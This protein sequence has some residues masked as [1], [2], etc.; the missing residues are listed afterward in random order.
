MNAAIATRVCILLTILFPTVARA[1]T[2]NT[3]SLAET[4]TDGTFLYEVKLIDEFLERFND[5]PNSYIRRE[6][7][8]LLGTDSIF[9]RR[10]MLHSLFN[11]DQSWGTDSFRFIQQVLDGAMPQYISFTD[12]NW[13][14][15]ANCVFTV[16]GKNV[17]VPVVLHISTQGNGAKWMIAGI[18][19]SEL[20]KMPCKTVHAFRPTGKPDFIPSSSHGTNFVYLQHVFSR[21]GNAANYFEPNVLQWERTRH[22]LGLVAE[23]QAT[24]KYVK[25]IEYHFYNVDGWI[26]TVSSFKRKVANSGWLISHL[27]PADA[28]AKVI[29]L[30]HLLW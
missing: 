3:F 4:T 29:A 17:A 14:A 10:R 23:G 30:Q 27:H 8:R 25:G 21:A 16:K 15:V 18:G 20:Y 13:Y 7:N 24:F 6:S 5:D 19:A 12:T 9:N 22:L 2:I 26:F 28:T 1:Q 11:K